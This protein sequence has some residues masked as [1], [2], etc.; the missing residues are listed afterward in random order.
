MADIET[1]WWLADHAATAWVQQ[2]AVDAGVERTVVADVLEAAQGRGLSFALPEAPE[3]HHITRYMM[4]Q[5]I[6]EFFRTETQA[7]KVLEVSGDEGAIAR[8]F[9]PKLIEYETCSYPEVDAQNLP[10]PEGS[11]DHVISD[12]VIEHL[13]NPQRAIDEA[14]RVLRTGGWLIVAS[15]FMDPVHTRPGNPH[16]F[17]RFTPEGLRHLLRDFST[18]YQCEGWGNRQAL[19]VALFGGVQR[20]QPVL[21]HPY[22]ETLLA[23]NEPDCP[24]SV[25]AIAQK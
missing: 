1:P 20:Y 15:A 19:A 22:L 18:I 12:Q 6:A 2:V 17:W 7:G 5:R 24:L 21:G 25:W 14:R 13:S 10:F 3:G 4:Y 11:Y 9:D 16:D 23:I 8:M